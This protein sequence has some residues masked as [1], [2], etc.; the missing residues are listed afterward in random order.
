MREYRCGQCKRLLFKGRLYDEK[1]LIEVL[2]RCGQLNSY[3]TDRRPAGEPVG[4]Y[5][6]D[7]LGG[8]VLTKAKAEA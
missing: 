8:Q 1:D 5:I 6:S 3:R 7:G 4:K 2:C